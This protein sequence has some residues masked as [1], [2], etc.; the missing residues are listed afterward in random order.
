MLGFEYVKDVYANDANYFV[1]YIAFDKAAFGVPN[2]SM[3]ELLVREAHGG[4]L[5]RHFSMRKTLEIYMN[6]SFGLG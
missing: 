1:V 6:I 3:L 2:C 5:M 4:G